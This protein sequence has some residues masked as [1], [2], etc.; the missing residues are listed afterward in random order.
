MHRSPSSKQMWGL[1]R[2]FWII[3]VGFLLPI[4][5]K[6]SGPN[7]II[8]DDALVSAL[9]VLSKGAMILLCIRCIMHLPIMPAAK[10]GTICV[11]AG[12]IDASAVYYPARIIGLGRIDIP[13]GTSTKMSGRPRIERAP[14][15]HGEAA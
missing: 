7:I 11:W 10:P 1:L 5:R 6:R 14:S 4:T 15:Q 2:S 12:K 8:P 13:L 3:G 9:H